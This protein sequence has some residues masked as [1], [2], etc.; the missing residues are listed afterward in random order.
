MPIIALVLTDI[1][2]VLEKFGLD[3]GYILSCCFAKT[4][5]VTSTAARIG[6]HELC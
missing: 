3:F 5:N 1:G 2:C 6:Y 4:Y